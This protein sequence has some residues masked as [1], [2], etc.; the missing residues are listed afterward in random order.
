MVRSNVK[1]FSDV[2]GSMIQMKGN[3]V[4]LYRAAKR[5]PSSLAAHCWPT[6]RI[7]CRVSHKKQQRANAS[8][9]LPKHEIGPH[10][11]LHCRKVP[12]IPIQGV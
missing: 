4:T 7:A 11:I 9:H 6:P 3:A 8:A 2:R 5:A 10:I 12:H 1:T